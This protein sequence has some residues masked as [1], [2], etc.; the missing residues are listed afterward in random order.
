[1]LAAGGTAGH[2][3]PALALAQELGRRGMVVDLVTDQRGDR[4]GAEFP[5]RAIHQVSSATLGAMSP[6]A[7]LRTTATLGRGVREAFRLLGR[8]RPAA[9]VGFGGYPSVPPLVAARL[10]RIPTALHEQNAILGRANRLLARFVDRIAVSF[11][12]TRQL[13]AGAQLKARLVG[14]PVRDAVLDWAMRPYRAPE[15]GGPY[16]LLVFGGSQGARVFADVVPAGLCRLPAAI[17]RNLFVVQQVREED[18]TRV[19]DA[20]SGSEIRT[21]LAP[22]FRNLP[23]EMARAQLVIARAG[24]STVAELTVLGRPSILVPLPHALDNDQLNNARRL[25]ASGAC[26]CVEQKDFSPDGLAAQI[27]GML[28]APERLSDAAA[29]A[30]RMGRPDAV[31]RLADTVEELTGQRKPGGQ[32]VGGT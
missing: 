26:W 19:E 16:H 25:E 10:R 9:V 17:R 2:L 7:V 27:A 24:A 23:E 29:A 13:A 18:L 28:G 8:V 30:K 11:E 3:F 31:V 32:D 6:A 15:P 22:F 5:A 4:Y 14:N 21:D 20:Y 12:D 1:M